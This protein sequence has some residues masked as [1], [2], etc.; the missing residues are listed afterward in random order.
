MIGILLGI[1]TFAVV[2]Y[3]DIQSDYKRLESN[4]INH[5][6]GAI[7]RTLALLPTFGCFYFPLENIQWWYW[8]LK[9][10]IVIG[11]LASVWWEFFDGFLNLK[12]KKSWR[13]NGSDDSDDS[14]TDNILQKLSPKQQTV[15]KW[16]L[17][18]IFTIL[19][20]LF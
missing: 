17:I 1:I 18:S 10:F 16:G 12:R 3:L 4:T 14:K 7:V 8:L 9:G 19:Y 20:I 13:Y 6:R 11:L 2:M 15:L 5:K